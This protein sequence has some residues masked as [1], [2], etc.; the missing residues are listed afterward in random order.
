[1]REFTKEKEKEIAGLL[2][3]A[4]FNGDA[5]EATIGLLASLCGSL[6]T[7]ADQGVAPDGVGI[8]K[9]HTALN[10]ALVMVGNPPIPVRSYLELLALGK[11]VGVLS[12]SGGGNV[13]LV[14][15]G[16]L[17]VAPD[18]PDE[19][20]EPD[21]GDYEFCPLWTP[22]V[23][24]RIRALLISEATT[25]LTDMETALMLSSMYASLASLHEAGGRA[26]IPEF[27]HGVSR[28]LQ[29]VTGELMSRK[30]FAVML[31]LMEKA[32]VVRLDGAY[33]TIHPAVYGADMPG[34]TGITA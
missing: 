16:S 15:D 8:D 5:R 25:P 30:A 26:A 32:E 12:L 20:D 31:V 2:A 27:Y 1:M 21:G 34:K 11:F 29:A 10:M 22:D 33:I 13:T 23:E 24:S 6:K 9:L 17:V 28:G 14:G 4:G 3:G 18:E 19:A 7:A